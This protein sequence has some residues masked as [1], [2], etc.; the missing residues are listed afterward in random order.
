[1]IFVKEPRPGRVKTRLGAGIGMAAAAQ[2]F[3]VQSR[4]LIRRLS[5]DPRWLTV[6]AIAPDAAVKSRCWPQCAIC[7][8][9]GAGDLGDR[10]TRAFRQFG[11]A[12]VIIIG[13]DIPSI[14]AW[15]IAEAIK[16]L[17]SH[18]V[19]FGPAPDGGYWL[20]GLKGPRVPSTFMKSV[21]WSSKYTLT[22]TIKTLPNNTRIG[23]LEALRDVDTADDL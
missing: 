2:W 11:P 7:W 10:M 9:Q 1:M 6:L 15:H 8:P 21:R 13:A 18:D 4:A 16:S 19:V 17:R 5:H 22:D 23:L 14:K 12:P 20:V 3:R